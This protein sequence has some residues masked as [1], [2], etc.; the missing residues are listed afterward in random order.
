MRTLKSLGELDQN[1]ASLFKN[2][3]SVCIFLEHPVDKVVIDIRVP[4]LE[5]TPEM[6]GL[7]KYG[8]P[9]SKLNTLNEYGL[10]IPDYNSG[11]DYQVSIMDKDRRVLLHS[12]TKD[13]IGLYCLR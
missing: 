12:N 2:L 3:C 13:N 9:F 6:N 8:L 5:D 11:V 10:I 1:I 7:R 4:T